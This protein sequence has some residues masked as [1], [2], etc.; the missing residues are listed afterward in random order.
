M[1]RFFL[2]NLSKKK[3]RQDKHFSEEIMHL[4]L[5]W[6]SF[7][8]DN[9]LYLIIQIKMWILWHIIWHR[10][11][12]QKLSSNTLDKPYSKPKFCMMK[13]YQYSIYIVNTIS[14]QF[15]TQ[16]E[17]IITIFYF[18]FQVQFNK[19]RIRTISRI[20]QYS[21]QEQKIKNKYI[22]IYDERKY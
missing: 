8:F 4:F 10:I 6:N 1:N 20:N 3:V 2:C 9:F 5:V 15:H 14:I 16:N 19:P 12:D 21:N 22:R 11:Q 17:N 13:M 18:N 7:R